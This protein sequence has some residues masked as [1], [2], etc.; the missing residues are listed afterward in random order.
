M[1]APQ[2]TRGSPVSLLLVLLSLTGVC[3]DGYKHVIIVHGI[4]DGP[5]E[6]KTLSL[7]ITKVGHLKS[8]NMCKKQTNKKVF[9]KWCVI[10]GE[11]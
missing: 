8:I 1:K 7:Y 2:T 6:F 3:I 11:T 10:F 4:F 9:K 5:K